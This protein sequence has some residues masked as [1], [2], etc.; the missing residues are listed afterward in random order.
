MADEPSASDG[1]LETASDQRL[2]AAER[3]VRASAERFRLL[4]EGARDFISYRFR[5]VP[6]QGFEHVSDGVM[7]ILGISPQRFLDSPGIWDELIHPDDRE[8]A[9]HELDPAHPVIMRWRRADGEY[10]Y[11]E[12]RRMAVYDD[13]GNLIAIE[14]LAYDVTEGVLAREEVEA[15]E[16][17]FSSLV[18]NVSDLILVVSPEGKMQWAS[19]SLERLLGYAGHEQTIDISGERV[20]PDDLRRLRSAFVHAQPPGPTTPVTARTLHKNGSWR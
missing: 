10:V 1:R 5:V 16:R 6:D 8:K 20:H 12:H 11:L 14:G 18:Q 13:D 15:S 19:P 4:V 2:R 7:S 3:E 9:G 17:R